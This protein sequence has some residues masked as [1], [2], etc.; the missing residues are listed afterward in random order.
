M[1]SGGQRAYSKPRQPL[2]RERRRLFGR[3]VRGDWVTADLVRPSDVRLFLGAMETPAPT[4]D[5]RAAR[6]R[7]QRGTPHQARR[8]QTALNERLVIVVARSESPEPEWSGVEAA[9]EHRVAGD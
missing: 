2:Q 9:V 3:E 4:S 8:Y 6:S 7:G 1:A 5:I